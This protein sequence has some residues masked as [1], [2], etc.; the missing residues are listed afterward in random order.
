V[1]LKCFR[2]STNRTALGLSTVCAN[3]I[4]FNSIQF[5]AVG[6]RAP[7]GLSPAISCSNR[8]GGECLTLFRRGGNAHIR[9]AYHWLK[10]TLRDGY[11][12]L[13][14]IASPL[15][16]ADFLTKVVMG[17][18]MRSSSDAASGYTSPPAIPPAVKFLT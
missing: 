7:W 18:A 4:R 5:L 10:D 13:R 8:P 11:I 15:N 17:P 3:S 14:D 16:L 12:D 1:C 2:T 6:P 9:A